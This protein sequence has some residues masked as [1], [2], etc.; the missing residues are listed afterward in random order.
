MRLP[1]YQVD[2]FTEQ[3]FGGN[4]AAVIPL[5]KW[6]DDALMQSIAAENDLS[7]TAFFVP[8]DGGYH[9][10]WFTPDCEVDLCGHGTLASAYVIK[11]HLQPEV[12]TL[13][14][15]SRSGELSVE[16]R[17]GVF[18]LDFPAHVPE[19]IPEE[20]AD[21]VA[22]VFD[23]HVLEVLG[24]D[25]YLVVFDDAE[26]ITLQHPDMEALSALDRRGVIIT[27]PGR[28]CDFVSRFFAPRVGVPEDPV[29]GSAHCTLV[30]FWAERLGRPA[31]HA[32]QVSERGGDLYCEARG[33]RVEIAGSA[34]QYLE[35]WIEV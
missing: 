21:R 31:L 28:D 30:P 20:E 27:A 18:A 26:A 11:R 29:T 22:A 34:V 10:R 16:A 7:E 23:R 24:S 19:P 13:H 17:G 2:A 8:E 5:E 14:F 35:G 3:L 25:D 6:L 1:I 9:I 33:E 4:P 15:Q 12:T 32:R